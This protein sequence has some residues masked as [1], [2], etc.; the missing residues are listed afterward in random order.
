LVLYYP[1]RPLPVRG[2]NHDAAHCRLWGEPPHRCHERGQQPDR[3]RAKSA[4]QN[5]PAAPPMAVPSSAVLTVETYCHAIL[6]DAR[7]RCGR[8]RR[9]DLARCRSF[10]IPKTVQFLLGDRSQ[11]RA[12]FR[13]AATIATLKSCS[14]VLTPEPRSRPNP[15]RFLWEAQKN[16]RDYHARGDQSG[17]EIT[18]FL[19]RGMGPTS[20]FRH[21]G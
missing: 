21:S 17:W 19:N 8:P 11:G 5:D 3:I 7:R 2:S 6:L 12:L 10:A 18:A 14:E 4:R 16:A 20:V 1:S 9:L 13:V 15:V